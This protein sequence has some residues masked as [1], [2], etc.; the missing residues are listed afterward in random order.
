MVEGP[1]VQEVLVLESSQSVPKVPIFYTPTKT[2]TFHIDLRLLAEADMNEVL[3][4]HGSTSFLSNSSPIHSSFFEVPMVPFS[5]IEAPT[6][7]SEMLEWEPNTVQSAALQ[8]KLANTQYELEVM[9]EH[10]LTKH[11]QHILANYTLLGCGA[12]V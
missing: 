3:E 4:A 2:H 10:L 5:A 1:S 8:M 6:D 7:V 11:T 12:P 9:K